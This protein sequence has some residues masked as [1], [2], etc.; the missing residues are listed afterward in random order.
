MNETVCITGASR[1]LGLE[2]ARLFY[3]RSYRV[4]P[5]VRSSAAAEA[6]LREMPDCRPIMADVADDNCTAVINGALSGQAESLDLLINNAG[7]SGTADGLEQVTTNEVGELFNVHGLGIIRT[8]QGALPMLERSARPRIINISSRLASLTKTAAGEFNH[9]GFTYSY[10]MAKAA[11]NMLTLC[12]HQELSERGV[13]VSAVHPGKILAGC[14]SHD[15]N[16]T[17]GEAAE[18]IFEW[19]RTAG[20][21]NSG[22]FVEAGAGILPW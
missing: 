9:G 3:A 2:L 19:C 5:V 6:L 11:Q 16:L 8:V 15:A 20:P 22:Q 17:P 4:F 1:G 10:R 14:A 18:R 13:H 7:I 12:L 21:H